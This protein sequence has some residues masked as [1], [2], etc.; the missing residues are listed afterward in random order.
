MANTPSWIVPAPKSNTGTT[1]SWVV[2]APT[3]AITTPTNTQFDPT[4]F[5]GLCK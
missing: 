5:T 3:V 1:P 4:I 2:K